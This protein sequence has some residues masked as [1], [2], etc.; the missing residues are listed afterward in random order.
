MARRCTNCAYTTDQPLLNQCPLCDNPMA[1]ICL[2]GNRQRPEP[3]RATGDSRPHSHTRPGSPWVLRG[4]VAAVVVAAAVG[5]WMSNRP[6]ANA[7]GSPT[8]K[9]VMVGGSVRQAVLALEPV[10]DT[11]G[12]V[13]LHDLL[14]PNAPRSGRFTWSDGSRVLAVTFRRGSIVNV[15]ETDLGGHGFGGGSHVTIDADP[16]DGPDDSAD[17]TE[18][19]PPIPPR[20]KGAP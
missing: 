14:A 20:R 11:S 16:G 10:P 17:P 19:D 8:G 9:R 15:S 18:T 12:R 6:R 4:V 2:T 1:I 7:V 3:R 5:L 13:S